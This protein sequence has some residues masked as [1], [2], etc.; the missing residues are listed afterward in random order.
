LVKA[1]N[2]VISQQGGLSFSSPSA[3]MIHPLPF[4]GL[5]GHGDAW[6]AAKAFENLTALAKKDG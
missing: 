4:A 5:M 6:N 3:G 2:Q 1:I